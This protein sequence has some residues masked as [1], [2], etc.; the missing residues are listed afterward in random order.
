MVQSENAGQPTVEQGPKSTGP[1]PAPDPGVTFP[2]CAH[3]GL[4]PI[5]LW[6]LR[7]DFPDGVVAEVLFCEGC[8]A[9]IN[10]TVVG[11]QKPMPKSP[12]NP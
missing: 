3:C 2:K 1:R 7:Y 4:D 6:R 12:V 11:F 8:R 5:V 10:A 9:A